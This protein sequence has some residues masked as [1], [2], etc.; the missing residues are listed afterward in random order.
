MAGR[1]IADQDIPL[2]SFC[3]TLYSRSEIDRIP[4]ES[5]GK[6]VIA[7]RVACEHRTR[8]DADSV[9]EGRLSEQGSLCV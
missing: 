8:V 5:I 1:L 7:A 6:T 3:E 9:P 2:K 4:D